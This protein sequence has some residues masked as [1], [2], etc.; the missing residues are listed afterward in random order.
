METLC[1]GLLGFHP[2]PVG[3]SGFSLRAFRDSNKFQPITMEESPHAA[4]H[5]GLVS[6]GASK[7]AQSEH[8]G[9]GAFASLP[10]HLGLPAVF[11]TSISECSK[12]GRNSRHKIL[13]ILHNLPKA[14]TL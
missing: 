1:S 5:S 8:V 12:V 10:S 9:V 3:P 4:A 13:P 6:A 14:L 2:G 7:S 11:I